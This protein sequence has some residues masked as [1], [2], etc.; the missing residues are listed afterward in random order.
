MAYQWQKEF[1]RLGWFDCLYRAQAE[2]KGH[3]YHQNTYQ[4]LCLL[5]RAVLPALKARA[6]MMVTYE[7]LRARLA[8]EKMSHAK[9][10]GKNSQRHP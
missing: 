5:T 8:A 2:P 10:F 7:L 3:N 4:Y 9:T 6:K 1:H